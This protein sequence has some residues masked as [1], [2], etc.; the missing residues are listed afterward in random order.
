TPVRSAI[1]L[2]WPATLQAGSRIIRGHAWSGTGAIAAVDYSLDG[3]RSWAPA[4]I[5]EP[6]IPTAGCRWEFLWDATPGQ[7]TITMRATDTEGH[8]QPAPDTVP[9]NDRGYEWGAYVAHP[10]EVL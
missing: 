2:A 8:T 1:A 6:N 5:R 9:W 4:E 10:V 3:G 7:H